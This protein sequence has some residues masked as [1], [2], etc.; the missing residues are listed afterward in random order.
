MLDDVLT[1]RLSCLRC[2]H[3]C[4]ATQ[5]LAPPIPCP[6]RGC[7]C[8]GFGKHPLSS[9][10]AG[11]VA[12]AVVPAGVVATRQQRTLAHVSATS[13]TSSSTSPADYFMGLFGGGGSSSKPTRKQAEEL[14]EKL[15]SAIDE[16]QGRGRCVWALSLT[17]TMHVFHDP[18]SSTSLATYARSTLFQWRTTTVDIAAVAKMTA[19]PEGRLHALVDCS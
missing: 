13:A 15:L 1:D 5:G 7:T 19:V 17:H 16:V 18:F 2:P 11:S 3:T 8:S 9:S 4:L 14:E 12:R 10:V 6:A